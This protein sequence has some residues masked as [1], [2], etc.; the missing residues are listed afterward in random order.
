MFGKVAKCVSVIISKTI[1]AIYKYLALIRL[2]LCKQVLSL[3][4]LC[5]QPNSNSN[6]LSVQFT[7]KGL[8]LLAIL[9]LLGKSLFL[10]F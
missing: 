8:V 9:W 4:S 10:Y 1:L 3:C 5:K 6:A 7:Y 2:A